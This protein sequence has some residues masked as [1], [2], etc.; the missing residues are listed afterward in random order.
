MNFFTWLTEFFP[1][2]YDSDIQMYKLGI[3]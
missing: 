3:V 2:W 1:L